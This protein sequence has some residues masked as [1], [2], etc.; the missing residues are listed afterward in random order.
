MEKREID[1]NNYQKIFE[2]DKESIFKS[3]ENELDRYPY[4]KEILSLLAG[5]V[6]ISAVLLMPGIGN[7]FAS[8]AW[9]GKGYKR[10]RLKQTLNRFRKQKFVEV[11]ENEAGRGFLRIT[12][13]GMKKALSF[14]LDEINVKKQKRWDKKWRIVIFD[15]SDKRKAL[16][17]EFRVRLKQMGFYPLQRSVYVHAY[18]CFDQVEFLRHIFGV[19]IE[20]TYIEATKVEGQDDLREFFKLG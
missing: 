1:W 10:K 9:S 16:R 8:T 7:V 3:L 13:E 19:D 15:I 2:K 5:G 18:P 12:K 11:V 17:D 20:V 6:L 4:S 14:K